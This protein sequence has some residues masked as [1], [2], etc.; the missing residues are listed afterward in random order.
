[1]SRTEDEAIDVKV[2]ADVSQG[3]FSLWPDGQKNQRQHTFSDLSASAVG[4]VK[5]PDP[6]AQIGYMGAK[7]DQAVV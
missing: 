7:L 4:M 2:K 6:P 5:S 1:M 3:P